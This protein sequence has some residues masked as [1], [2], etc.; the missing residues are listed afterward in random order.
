MIIR[1]IHSDVLG[2]VVGERVHERFKIFLATYFADV[3]S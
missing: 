2:D 1:A 3:F